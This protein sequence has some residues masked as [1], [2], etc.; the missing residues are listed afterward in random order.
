MYVVITNCMYIFCF[1]RSSI[2]LLL[3]V[4]SEAAVY[5]TLTAV[6]STK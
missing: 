2:K 3:T 1:R 4:F 6:Y 5:F